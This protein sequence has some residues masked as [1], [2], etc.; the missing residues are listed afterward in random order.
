MKHTK[1]LSHSLTLATIVALPAAASAHPSHDGE[2]AAPLHVDD[3]YDNCFFD[4]HPELTQAEFDEF[5]KEGGA[6]TRFHQLANAEPLGQ[7]NFDVSLVFTST[8]VDDSKG[9]WNNTMSHPDAEHTLGHQV[10]FPRL[11]VRMGVSDSV[12]VGVWGSLDPNSNYGFVGIES[13]ISLLRQSADLPVSVAV[14]PNVSSLLGPDELFLANAGVDLSVSHNFRGLSPYVG[15]A[16]TS[17][18]AVEMSDEVDLDNGKANSL[19][20]IAGVTYGWKGLRLAGEAEFGALNT[21]AVRV[22]GAF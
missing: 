13:K 3:S 10:A 8:P 16:G 7:W 19:A 14:R 17:S 9:A 4:L 5:A 21:Y 2:S 1:L 11:F 15:V 18:I 20:A 6:I 12:D 22:G